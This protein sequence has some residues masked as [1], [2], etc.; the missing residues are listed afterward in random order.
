MLDA[1]LLD[2]IEEVAR[3]VTGCALP[4]GGIQLV[5]CGDFFQLPPVQKRSFN[6]GNSRPPFAF[7]AKCWPNVVKKTMVLTKVTTAHHVR[8]CP[9]KTLL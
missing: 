6:Q 5:L 4:F 2:K 1:A 8:T 3:I 9:C 7:H